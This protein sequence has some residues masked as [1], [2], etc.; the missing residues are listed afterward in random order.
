MCWLP[1]RWIEGKDE[2]VEVVLLGASPCVGCHGAGLR[3]RM[4][5]LKSFYWGASPCVGCHDAG[6]RER[7]NWLKSFYWGHPSVL[8]AVALD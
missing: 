2:L 1:W 3:E 6:L 5:W 8:V 7:M 4:N